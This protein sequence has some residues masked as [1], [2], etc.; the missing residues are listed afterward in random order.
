MSLQSSPET[1]ARIIS[2]DAYRGFVMF[3]IMAEVFEFRHVAAA[4]P[5]NPFW[6]FLGYNQRHVD[7]A[8]C[9]LHDL[10]QPSFS[11]LV[12]VALPFSLMSRRGRGAD[13]AVLWQHTLKRSLILV[14]LG[15]FLR[16]LHQPQTNYTFVDT[17]TQIGLGYPFLFALGFASKRVQWIS[18]ALILVGY[19]LFF[20]MYPLPGP[21][22]NWADAGVTAD[23]PFNLQGFSAH[24]N[25]NTN[26]TAAFDRWFL[27]LFPRETPFL[28][29]KGGYATLNFIPTLAT[30]LL[31]LFAGQ[32]LLERQPGMLK[33][34]VREGL[35]L[36]GVALILA[37]IGVNPIVK[38]IW[39]PGWVMFSGG[40]CFLLLA[41]F[42][43]LV[44]QKL[45]RRPFYFLFVI[46]AN[47]IATYVL[48]GFAP[49]FIDESLRTHFGADYAHWF[50]E[51][52]NVIIRGA[53]QLGLMWL[54]LR[55]MYIRKIFIKI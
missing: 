23:W 27:N 47:S 16:S 22:F 51:P 6:H 48:M 34:F 17:L 1:P 25:K 29:N 18:F 5:D 24:W 35:I 40:C 55:W 54:L 49:S 46:G 32:Q 41:T 8:G 12:G 14:L 13:L 11:F 3:L 28:F 44:D 26:P 43:W 31:G 36:L 33:R 9:S 42:Y 53:F 20:A 7:W 15:I 38:R 37:W 30:M 10:I 39:T 4:L 2:V 50:G 21:D 45:I 52:Y 19:W